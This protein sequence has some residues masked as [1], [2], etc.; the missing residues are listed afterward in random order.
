MSQVLQRLPAGCE[1]IH[2][3]LSLSRYR[4]ASTFTRGAS[5]LFATKVFSD[6]GTI[7]TVYLL[8]IPIWECL[9]LNFGKKLN[10]RVYSFKATF[11]VT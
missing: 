4:L 10:W 2:M 9:Q 11:E 6:R 8:D 3:W 1:H 7:R 5:Y